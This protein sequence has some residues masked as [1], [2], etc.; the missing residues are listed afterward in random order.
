MKTRRNLIM[1]IGL[2]GIG[3]TA[4]SF[5]VA[6]EEDPTMKK[7]EVIR[8]MNGEVQTFD[9]LVADNSNYTPQDYLNDLGF[10]DDEDV[11]IVDIF[12]SHP[13]G[14]EVTVDIE[15]EH[16]GEGGENH[17]VIHKEVIVNEEVEINEEGD[18][19]V[20]V[21]KKV[22]MHDGENH[23]EM[24][25]DSILAIH[26]VNPDSGDVQIRKVVIMETDEDMGDPSENTFIIE[27]EPVY[28]NSSNENGVNAHV[29]VFGDEDFTLVIVSE[30]DLS[31]NKRSAIVN[32]AVNP[33]NN[34]IS[35][36]P[37]PAKQSTELQLN[38]K[39]EAPTTITITDVNGA[40]VAEM[41]LGQFSG[42]FNHTIDLSK[43]A[44]GVYLVSVKHGNEQEVEKLIV[45]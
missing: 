13:E 4:L 33:S 35:M 16:D 2:I 29:Q 19:Q 28:E 26:G 15:I 39:D 22:I 38:F 41:E 11:I 45:E 37:N 8:S 3:A 17:Q 40:V 31:P 30:E 43:W 6:N 24:N 12:G 14:E 42:Q 27:G 5:V 7:Y 21:E 1:G 44:K 10:G 18:Q 34:S 9:T 25:I 20:W 23:E 36:F 32:D